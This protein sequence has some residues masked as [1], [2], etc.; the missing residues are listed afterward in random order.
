M[1]LTDSANQ[2]ADQRFPLKQ[3][4][5]NSLCRSEYRRIAPIDYTVVIAWEALSCGLFVKEI[6]ADLLD[7]LHLSYGYKILGTPEDSCL[8]EGETIIVKMRVT[9][10]T[11]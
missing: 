2:L 1:K 3:T 4:G 8:R 6:D 9:E 10:V 5:T 7:L 11:L